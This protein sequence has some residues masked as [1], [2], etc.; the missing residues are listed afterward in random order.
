MAFT[1]KFVSAAAGGGG[2]GN[3]AGDPYTWAEMIT[4]SGSNTG[5]RYNILKGTYSLSSTDTLGSGTAAAP[6]EFSGYGTSEQ[7]QDTLRDDPCAAALD[8]S[9]FPVIDYSG[10]GGTLTGGG[11]IIVRNLHVKNDNNGTVFACGTNNAVMHCKI[12]N[13]HASGSSVVACQ[14]GTSGS[15]VLDCDLV[16]ASTA[17]GAVALNADRGSVGSSRLSGTG[18]GGIGV[19]CGGWT[20]VTRCALIGFFRAIECNSTYT[21]VYGCSFRN[22]T[23]SAVYHSAGLLGFVGNVVYSTQTGSNLVNIGGAVRAHFQINNARST[24]GSDANEGDWPVQGEVT[25]TADPF[26][27]SSDLT[28]NATAGGGAAC[29]DVALGPNLD[30]GAAQSAGA[31][32]G[33]GLLV[34]LGMAGGMA[35]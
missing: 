22:F 20:T 1:E 30:A 25:L 10:G 35:G 34:P 4:H 3:S 16:I 21:F 33:G 6:N 15:L 7:D 27:S 17:N 12:E 32:G 9:N 31:G 11:N 14:I 8:V 26:T 19:Q 28:L 5:H 2:T 23:G 29:K 18:I 13:T 24:A